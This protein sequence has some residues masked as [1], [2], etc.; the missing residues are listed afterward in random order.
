M[1]LEI[2]TEFREIN[3]IITYLKNYL[4]EKDKDHKDKELEMSVR[5]GTLVRKAGMTQEA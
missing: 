1:E 2:I 5:A 4:R 3:E